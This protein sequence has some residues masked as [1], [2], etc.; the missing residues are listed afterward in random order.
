M[1][2]ALSSAV[3]YVRAEEFSD[4]RT[5]NAPDVVRHIMMFGGTPEEAMGGRCAACSR[6]ASSS[7][8]G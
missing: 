2:S 3:T 6:R 1:F 5:Y 8:C 4:I 7:R